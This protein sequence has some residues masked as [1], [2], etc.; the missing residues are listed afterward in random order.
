MVSSTKEKDKKM[1]VFSL[2][3]FNDYE[4][5]DLLGVF[6]SKQDLLAYVDAESVRQAKEYGFSKERALLLGFDQLGYAESEL[7]QPVDVLEVVEYL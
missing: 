7:G 2:V 3:G 6:G 5:S 1:K 4:G